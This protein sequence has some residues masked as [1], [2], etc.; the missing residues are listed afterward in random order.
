VWKGGNEITDRRLLKKHERTSKKKGGRE[1]SSSLKRNHSQLKMKVPYFRIDYK[2][3]K[4]KKLCHEKVLLRNPTR[5]QRKEKEKKGGVHL[6][7]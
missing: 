6:G 2:K 3:E 5:N 4:K 1:F 7:T